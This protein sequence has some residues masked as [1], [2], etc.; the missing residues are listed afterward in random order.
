VQVYLSAVFGET[1]SQKL[2]FLRNHQAGVIPQAEGGYICGGSR[3]K[4]SLPCGFLL[5][6]AP[7]GRWTKTIRETPNNPTHINIMSHTL[8]LHTGTDSIKAHNC[9][10]ESPSVDEALFP[11]L[12][13]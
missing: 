10:T 9:E 4:L 1:V 3:G 11:A 6:E 13:L 8:S 2:F 7:A 5:T 12:L